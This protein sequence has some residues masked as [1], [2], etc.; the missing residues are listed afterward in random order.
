MNPSKRGKQ[1]QK[2]G[3]LLLTLGLGLDWGLAVSD[4]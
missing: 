3:I 2:Q 4:A 1:V